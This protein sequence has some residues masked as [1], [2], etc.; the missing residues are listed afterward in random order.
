[1]KLGRAR[2]PTGDLTCHSLMP[3]HGERVLTRMSV[4]MRGV[5]HRKAHVV[6]SEPSMPDLFEKLTTHMGRLSEELPEEADWSLTSERELTDTD[7]SGLVT[8]TMK[9]F[10]VDS[11]SFDHYL[12]STQDPDPVD[13]AAAT[14]EAVNK[15]LARYLEEEILDAKSHAVPMR[16]LHEGLQQFSTEFAQAY[17]R[18]LDRVR[19]NQ[20]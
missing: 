9:D 16:E 17:E 13:L 10:K 18:S 7:D 14:T 12:M 3:G 4:T 11:I 8:V 15:V 19:S 5:P 2:T 6:M 1:M 20:K